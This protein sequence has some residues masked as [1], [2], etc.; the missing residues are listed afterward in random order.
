MH[1]LIALAPAYFLL[2]EDLPYIGVD[3]WVVLVVFLAILSVFDFW[4]KTTGRTF[5]GLRPHEKTS[6]ASFAWAALGIVI[7]LWLVPKGP[8]TA[9]LFGVA[10]VDPLAGELRSRYGQ[11]PVT[12]AVA[13][14]AYV[15]LAYVGMTAWNELDVLGRALIAVVGA[16]VAI[17][18]EALKTRYVD[19]DFT[20]LVFPA[21][22]MALVALAL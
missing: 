5:L 7:A 20:M 6:T 9:A 1:L 14:I 11:K 15:V 13:A 21:A 12:V 10:V 19:D 22:A 16:C 3:R 4:R 18:S 8:A 17:P 2:P